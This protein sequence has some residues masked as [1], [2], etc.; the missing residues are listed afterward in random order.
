MEIAHLTTCKVLFRVH[1]QSL[2]FCILL[3]LSRALSTS[4][5]IMKTSPSYSGW[6]Q[7]PLDHISVQNR[8][9]P[10]VKEATIPVCYIL[11]LMTLTRTK[12]IWLSTTQHPPLVN[13]LLVSELKKFVTWQYCMMYSS[14]V[15]RKHNC[16]YNEAVCLI[17]I[18]S[19][20][21]HFLIAFE[22]CFGGER[23]WHR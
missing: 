9:R 20:W 13:G 22:T 11:R 15:G 6:Y 19:S 7:W 5:S 2:E 8:C 21:S 23:T 16:K 18:E 17:A 12:A 4:S 1:V 3:Q 10:N 14:Y